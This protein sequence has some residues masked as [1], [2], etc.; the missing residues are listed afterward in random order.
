M[1]RNLV[2]PGSIPLDT[3]LL[4]G[5][6]NAMIAIGY[7]AQAVL[8]TNTIVDGL[9][10]APTAPASLTITIGPGSITQLSVVDTLAYGSIPADT[11]DPLVKMGINL[12]PATFVLAAPLTSGQSINYLIQAALQ[13]SDTNPVVLPYYNAANPA[14]P[15]SGPDN[16]GVAQN[17]LR[18]QRVQLQLKGGAAANTGLQITQPVDN[19]WVGLYVITVAY[20]QTAITS[21]SI[22]L[23]SNA[24]F[25]SWKLP[26]LRPGFASGVQTY[27]TSGSF[28]VPAGVTQVE[29]EVWGGGSGS[30]ASIGTISS[31]GGS[32]GGYA[33]K[34]ITGL[35]GGQTVSVAVGIGGAA[36][37]TGGMAPTSGGN[38]SFGSYV[39]AYGGQLNQQ[40]TVANP[41][42]GATS[43]GTPAG[44]GGVGGDINIVGSAGQAGLLNQGGLGGAAPMG[45][46]QNSGTFG[47]PGIFPGGGASGAGTGA[48]QATPYN[49]AAGANGLV[50]VRW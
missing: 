14:Q 26:T 37:T 43:Y 41:Q 15:Y 30:Y 39:T 45:G 6:R 17:T 36:G 22:A 32:G 8:G 5:N 29:V 13:E 31:G 27:L 34:R 1:D 42:N 25:L 10:C 20:G 9:T 12:S 19:G 11:M 23:Y 24:P 49:G 40:A 35:T 44:V 16:S 4:S 21:A 38:S 47:L 2:Y 48:N 3:D 33:R 46:W 28:T 18:I 50:I 7:L